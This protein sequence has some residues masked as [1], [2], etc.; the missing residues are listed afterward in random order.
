MQG[1]LSR[2]FD[3][4]INGMQNIDKYY[5]RGCKDVLDNIHHPFTVYILGKLSQ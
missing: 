4:E 3:P 2:C 1:G 5:D